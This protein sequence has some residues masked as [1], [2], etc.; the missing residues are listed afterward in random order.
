MEPKPISPYALH[1]LIGENYAKLFHSLYGLETISLRYFNVFGPRQD[2]EGNYACLIPRFIKLINQWKRPTINGHGRQTRDFTFVDDVVEANLLAAQTGNED[3]FGQTFNIGAGR[4][5][6][7]NQITKEI[8][9]LAKRKIKPIYGPAVI[10]PRNTLADI[11]KAKRMLGWRPQ[12]S[13]ERGLQKTYQ[14]FVKG[15]VKID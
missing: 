8:S 4:N 12:V 1:K 10:E 11:N 6:S 2:P 14:Y 5:K 9:K 13:F 7:V 3:C 15:K